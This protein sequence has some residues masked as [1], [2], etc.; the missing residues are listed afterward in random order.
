MAYLDRGS[1]TGSTGRRSP[2]WIHQPAPCMMTRMITTAVGGK[3]APLIYIPVAV[4]GASP[5]AVAGAGW[6]ASQ[7]STA[8]LSGA[9]PQA[10]VGMVAVPQASVRRPRSWRKMM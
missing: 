6:E 9:H 5:V 10:V 3:R 1:A 2:P 7:P 4:A 8:G